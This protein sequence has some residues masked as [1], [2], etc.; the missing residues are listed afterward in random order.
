MQLAEAFD[1]LSTRRVLLFGGKGGVGKTTISSLAALHLTQTRRVILFTTDP[2]SNLS[3]L[4]KPQT[5]NLEIEE[6]N[7]Q[8]LYA[9]FLENNLTNLLEIGDRG[10][11]L[12]RDELRRFF[13]LSLPGVD[14]LMA[15][16]RIGELAEENEDAI[17]IVD[18][19]P[20]GHTVRMLA[21]GAHF[22][23]FAEALDT[24][25]A[26][27]RGMVRQFTRRN[28]RD[29]IDE[30]IERFDEDA[31]RRR[32]LLAT[33]A[34]V[35]VFLSEPWVVEQTVKLISEVR[36]DGIEV[37]FAILNRAVVDPD[38]DRDRA[39]QKRDAEARKKMTAVVDAP[40][41]CVPLDSVDALRAYLNPLPPGEGGRRPGE[42]RAPHP[43]LRGTFSR[44]EKGVPKLLFL[45][46]KGGV[47][48]TTCA[49]SIALQ[50]AARNPTKRYTIISVDPAHSLR[51]V[52][53]TEKPPQNLTVEIVET[54]EKWRRLRETLGDEI[55]RAV[56]AITPGNF[57]IEYDA[58]AI[59]KLIDIA[60]PGADELFAVSR[61][62]DLAADES[63]EMIIVDTAPTG[64]FLRLLELPK[65]AG[66]WVREFMRILLR[67]RELV[68]PGAL[69]EELVSASRAMHALEETLRS[70]RASTIVVTRPER[71]VITETKRL[72]DS[73]EQRKMKIGGVIANYVT[74]DNDCKCDR[75][76]RG[77]EMT[78]LSSLKREMVT[79]ERRDAPVTKLAE[80]A[81]LFRVAA[82]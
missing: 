56:A 51:D 22:R 72:L 47:G 26:K 49:T 19:A 12:D 36:N 46:G 23:Q 38:C 77:H 71:I 10:T 27:H 57:S 11:Y 31:R 37:P 32:E 33:G 42:G 53:A 20:T 6:L 68:P 5:A 52:F 8:Q 9:K 45:A 29:A 73:L 39:L 44:W 76:M 67:Y 64:H 35:P 40:R 54:R 79:V 65:T 25:E 70:E 41:S 16:M 21:A 66:D 14:E 43:P 81:A 61:L 80:L 63:Q 75:S 58:E 69:G 50:L 28:V 4:L 48:K 34:F 3:D 7:A 60:P 74:P 55:E 13:E 1:S 62:A 24:L 18:T 2:A 59:R 30:Y 78:A 15:W 82:D 17:V